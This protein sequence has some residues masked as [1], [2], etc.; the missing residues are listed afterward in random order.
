M[1]GWAVSGRRSAP[2]IIAVF[3]LLLILGIVTFVTDNAKRRAT[4]PWRAL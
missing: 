3:V 4:A 1:F 2:A